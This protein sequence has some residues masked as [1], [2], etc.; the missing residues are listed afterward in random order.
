M[1]ETLLI[2]IVLISFKAESF[3]DSFIDAGHKVAQE[4]H[5]DSVKRYPDSSNYWV[6]VD[7]LNEIKS[8][9]NICSCLSKHLFVLLYVDSTYESV[10]IQSSVHHFGLETNTEMDLVK[11]DSTNNNFMI[12]KAWPL[13]SML[14]L[15]I[16]GKTL[17]IGY[18]GK[19]YKFMKMK[20]KTLDIPNSQRGLFLLSSDIFAQRNRLNAESL[21]VYRKTNVD[22][23]STLISFQELTS[24]IEANRVSIGCSD[25]FHINSMTIKGE[26]YRHFEIEYSDGYITIYEEPEGGRS[27]FEILN[28]DS[29]NKQV[30]YKNE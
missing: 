20:L 25:D 13:S 7:Y 12:E 24:L 30:F 8:G 1:K 16:K 22:A 18:N 10:I 2:L 23:T 15:T 17:L 27:R 14:K 29:L 9:R 28:R 3:V 11:I 4:A 21:L 5:S 19:L 26:V 6:N